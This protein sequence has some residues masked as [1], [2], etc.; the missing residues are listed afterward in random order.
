M[1][2]KSQSINIRI[3]NDKIKVTHLYREKQLRIGK[4]TIGKL[5]SRS[6]VSISFNI[7]SQVGKQILMRPNLE[8]I[9]LKD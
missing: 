7:P 4:Y 1:E 5:P 3:K 9:L 6:L 2:T 8:Q